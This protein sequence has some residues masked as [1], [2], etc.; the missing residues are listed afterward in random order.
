MYTQE[1]IELC[2]SNF[3]SGIK[4][5]RWHKETSGVLCVLNDTD[6]K[7]SSI[8]NILLNIKRTLNKR[9]PDLK[10]LNYYVSFPNIERTNAYSAYIKDEYLSQFLEKKCKKQEA[11]S[12]LL[13]RSIL[14]Q[15]KKQCT[16][17]K[18]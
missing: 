4:L 6:P 15:E 13:L 5:W 17:K 2:I 10:I 11:V 9:F 18:K 16:R 3:C 12:K 7:P 8:F 14:K 1:E